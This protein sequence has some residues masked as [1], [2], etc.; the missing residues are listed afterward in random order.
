MN[1]TN[2]TLETTERLIRER[3]PGH[4]GE[5][6]RIDRIEGSSFDRKD[7]EVNYIT[8]YLAPG[9]PPLTSPHYP[10]GVAPNSPTAARV[11]ATTPLPCSPQP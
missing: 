7:R 11:P 5:S 10:V 9:S 3:F 4:F 6:Y 2:R 1:G 8:V